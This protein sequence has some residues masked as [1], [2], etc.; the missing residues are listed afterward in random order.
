VLAALDNLAARAGP[1]DT[2]F[3]FHEGHGA[4]GTDGSYYLISH[5]AKIS[6]TQVAAGTGISQQALIEKL[7]KLPVKRALLVFN[8]CHSGNLSP[9][10]D[11]GSAPQSKN[12]PETAAYALLGTGSGRIVIT[13]CREEQVSYIGD[14]TLSYFTQA[15][16]DGLHGKGIVPRGG[17]ISVFDLYS[18]LYETVSARVKKEADDTQEPELTIIQGVG[19]FA[20]SLYRGASDTDLGLAE[21]PADLSG[22]SAVRTVPE[23][24]ARRLAGIVNIINTTGQSGGINNQGTINV[25]GDMVARDKTV[26]NHPEPRASNGA[27]HDPRAELLRLLHDLQPQIA[28]LEL[29]DWQKEEIAGNLRVA[30]LMAAAAK[31]PRE[32]LLDELTATKGL[33]ES[34]GGAS[35]SSLA[36]QLAQA[37]S[38]AQQW[39][40]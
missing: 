16:V 38:L 35:L 29:D 27:G 39:L 36:T 32:K 4:Y 1:D 26:I 6:G 7:R 25:R 28:E 21:Q 31:P 24:K 34:S 8:A 37:L 33:L 5:D 40:G 14:G 20:V 15:L 18:Y 22:S 13:A 10:L 12:L 9:S 30:E 23:A 3:Y 17:A 2:V 11:L 19:P